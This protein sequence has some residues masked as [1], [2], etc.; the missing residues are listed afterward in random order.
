MRH[1]YVL[2]RDDDKK[3]L[4]LREM[5]EIDREIFAL[6]CEEAYGIDTLNDAVSRKGDAL[7]R[8]LRTD[9]IFPLGRYAEKIATAVGELL[10]GGNDT[11]VELLFDD[12]EFL[13]REAEAEEEEIEI[14]EED[15]GD[16][17]DDMLEDDIGSDYTET[18]VGVD[19]P[20]KIADDEAEDVDAA[21]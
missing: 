6:L 11:S 9:N 16:T 21:T 4:L 13:T 14:E 2:L 1:K 8:T 18:N 3:E 15:A 17:L 20:L 10:E 7:V 19:S 12:V 5:G